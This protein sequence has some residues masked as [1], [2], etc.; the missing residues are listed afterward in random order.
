MWEHINHLTDEMYTV[1]QHSLF[2]DSYKVQRN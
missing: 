1:Q 2:M